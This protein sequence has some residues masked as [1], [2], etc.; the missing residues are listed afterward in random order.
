MKFQLYSAYF[1]SIDDYPDSLREHLK[2]YCE[3]EDGIFYIINPDIKTLDYMLKSIPEECYESTNGWK[4][5]GI[6]IDFK[7]KTITLCDYY[8]E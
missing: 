6:E 2:D 5:T 8:L 7:M 3:I 4:P 1:Y